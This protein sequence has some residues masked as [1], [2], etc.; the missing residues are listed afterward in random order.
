MKIDVWLPVPVPARLAW[1]VT[2]RGP[3]LFVLLRFLYMPDGL[4]RAWG[5][6]LAI[7]ASP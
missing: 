6:Y 2:I 1:R 4:N 3:L 7:I 5:L